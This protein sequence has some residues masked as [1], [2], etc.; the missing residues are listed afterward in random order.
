MSRSDSSSSDI[1]PGRGLGKRVRPSSSESSDDS[2]IVSR[3]KNVKRRALSESSD[4]DGEIE[5]RKRRKN[6]SDSKPVIASESDSDS[7]SLGD[8]PACPICLGKLYETTLQGRPESCD[9]T[10][11]IEC[12]TAWSKNNSTCPLCRNSFSKIKISLRGDILEELPV[13]TVEPEINEADQFLNDILCLVCHRSDQEDTLLLCDECDDA[14]HC[15]CLT[16]PLRSVPV[17][18][19]FCPR[20]REQDIDSD[21]DDEDFVLLGD[22]SLYVPRTRATERVRRSVQSTRRTTTRQT[23]RSSRRGRGGTQRTSTTRRTTSTRKR[24]STATTKRKKTRRRATRKRKGGR[25]LTILRKAYAASSDQQW[26]IARSLGLSDRLL[27]KLNRNNI[28]FPV[29]STEEPSTSRGTSSRAE[30]SGHRRSLLGVAPNLTIFG[31]NNSFEPQG[32]SGDDEPLARRQE[33]HTKKEDRA[34]CS[35]AS[36]VDFLGGLLEKQSVLLDKKSELKM[37]SQGTLRLV[38]GKELEAMAA[39]SGRRSSEDS[40]SSKAKSLKVGQAAPRASSSALEYDTR[41]KPQR[42]SRVSGSTVTAISR[43]IEDVVNSNH[44]ERGEP[45]A[46]SQK[47]S[48]KNKFSSVPYADEAHN[49]ARGK[50]IEESQGWIN[51]LKLTVPK[52]INSLSIFRDLD[53]EQPSTSRTDSNYYRRSEVKSEPV[54]VKEEPR[55]NDET[56]DSS[57][58]RGHREQREVPRSSD[59]RYSAPV[60][61]LSRIKIEPVDYSAPQPPQTSSTTIEVHMEAEPTVKSEVSDDAPIGDLDNV[62]RPLG[63]D[64][65][66]FPLVDQLKASPT[67]KYESAEDFVGPETK[68]SQ[69]T[70]L[71]KPW[72]D[73]ELRQVSSNSADAS[74]ALLPQSTVNFSHTEGYSSGM[75]SEES[76]SDVERAV[77]GVPT[78]AD[79]IKKK[80]PRKYVKYFVSREKFKDAVI[81]EVGPYLKKFYKKHQISKEDYK[82][83]FKKVIKKVCTSSSEKKRLVCT[84][85]IHR[86]CH[87]Y[88]KRARIQIKLDCKFG[89]GT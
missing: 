81:K 25:R 28:S 30:S 53:G 27:H 66:S 24:K 69:A 87:T 14:Y 17:G 2:L 13:K 5:W 50:A 32:S 68:F 79:T 4:P 29:L 15:S 33:T 12:I 36:G 47:K 52:V 26:R 62:G 65:G 37:D 86:L 88:V 82:E 56:C 10:F 75:E 49:V 3:K 58:H 45:E 42:V 43:S 48:K 59:K 72:G 18:Q 16:P 85:A 80:E 83:I 9:H 11:C 41:Y 19:W 60:L 78:D 7:G 39:S 74:D 54:R 38:G 57:S 23:N 44:V 63:L 35:S 67:V 89:E 1:G 70:E 8:A 6:R 34:G 73:M 76:F 31:D 61:D 77:P 22:Y 71:P 51:S 55:D 46:T 21:G 20:C 40:L 64:D 84:K